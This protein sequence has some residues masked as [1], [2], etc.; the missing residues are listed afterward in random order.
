MSQENVEMIE[1]AIEAFNRRDLP[2]L[3]ELSQPGLE[4]ISALTAANLGGDEY[5]DSDAFIDYFA[6]MD[7]SWEE[8]QIED[9]R[10][11]DA[12]D[13]HVVTLCRLVGVGKQ[14]GVPVEREVGIAYEI[15]DGRMWRIRSYLD[16][17]DALRAVGLSE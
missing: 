4:I 7:E 14:S 12:G 13:R 6:A 3:R 5:R 11:L 17:A 15:Q 10:Y 1:A 8:W 9:A 16:P 2:A